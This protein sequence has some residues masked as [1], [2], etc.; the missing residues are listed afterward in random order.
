[1]VTV[2]LPR[3]F[4]LVRHVD[5]T[6]VSGVGVVAFGM[7][8]SDGH[9]VLRWCS[10]HPATSTWGSLEDMLAIHGHGE[11]TSV[12]W[13]D[14][15]A[16]ELEEVPGASR[17]GRRARRRAERDADADT[18][19]P[20]GGPGVAAGHE[21]PAA[22]TGAGPGLVSNGHARRRDPAVG[23]PGP[24]G[25]DAADDDGPDT[26]PNPRVPGRH[27]RSDQVEPQR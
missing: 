24:S 7:V 4:A 2:V 12:Q 20:A 9:V 13:I 8:F 19:S 22:G 11:A 6:G 21:G 1:M 5:Y 10:S 3:R 15:P 23:T 18:E 14:A 26:V 25:G 16:P 17:M 27:R